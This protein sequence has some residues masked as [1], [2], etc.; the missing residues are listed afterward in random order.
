MMVILKKYLS[1]FYDFEY[2]KLVGLFARITQTI[3]S[4]AY[5]YKINFILSFWTWMSCFDTYRLSKAYVYPTHIFIQLAQMLL[6]ISSL[7][8]R[9]LC[10][11]DGLLFTYVHTTNATL[12]IS[13][14]FIDLKSY[15]EWGAL[16]QKLWFSLNALFQITC[17]WPR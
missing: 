2:K 9:Y 5:V 8:T 6:N 4:T 17:T 10:I 11:K 13:C 12:N 1:I 3:S 15:A 16:W 14:C 7:F